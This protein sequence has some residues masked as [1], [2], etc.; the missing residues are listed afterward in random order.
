M[1]DQV[2]HFGYIVISSPDRVGTGVLIIG[3]YDE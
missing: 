2:R 3:Y 1:V